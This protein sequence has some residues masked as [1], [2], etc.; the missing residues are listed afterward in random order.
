M[1]SQTVFALRESYMSSII[2]ASSETQ[3]PAVVGRAGQA[4]LQQ[5]AV[6]GASA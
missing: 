1:R 2:T 4:S 3:E 5:V 6:G